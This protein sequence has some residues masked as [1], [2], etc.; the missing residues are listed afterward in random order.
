MSDP[1]ILSW[2]SE[3]EEEEEEEEKEEMGGP[4]SLPLLVLIKASIIKKTFFSCAFR[5]NGWSVI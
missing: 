2:S 4:V 3:E 1:D 5:E